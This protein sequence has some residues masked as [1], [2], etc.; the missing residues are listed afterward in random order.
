MR[1]A[2]ASSQHTLEHELLGVR[3]LSRDRAWWIHPS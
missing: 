1:P 2:M 3:P